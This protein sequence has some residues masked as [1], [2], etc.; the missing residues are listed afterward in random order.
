MEKL[1]NKLVMYQISKRGDKCISLETTQKTSKRC[2]IMYFVKYKSS[3]VV[4][5]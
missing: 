5:Q 4:C 3:I 2:R 1:R